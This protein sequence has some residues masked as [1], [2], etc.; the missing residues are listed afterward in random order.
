MLIL[1][2][3]MEGT[4]SQNYDL[5]PRFYFMKCRK[6]GL[7]K[8][9]KVT[10]LFCDKIRTKTLIKNLRHGSLHMN[11]LSMCLK[12]HHSYLNIKGDIKKIKVIK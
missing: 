11:V 4:M 3:M 5:G 9:L 6:L 2:T 10:R 1:D 12:C 7:K 8:C